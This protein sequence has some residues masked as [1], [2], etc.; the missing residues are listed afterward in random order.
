[1]QI[2]QQVSAK[3]DVIGRIILQKIVPV[4]DHDDEGSLSARILQQE[5]LAYSEAIGLVLSGEVE[6]QD[7]KVI[8][9]R[10]LPKDKHA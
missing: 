5:H 9:R 2:D 7:R 8:H 10:V 1:M 6:V 3:D 4:S